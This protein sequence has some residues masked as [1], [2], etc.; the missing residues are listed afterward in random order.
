MRNYFNTTSQVRFVYPIDGDCLNIH[1]GEMKNGCL[2]IKVKVQAQAGADIYIDEKK[3]EFDGE[4]FTGQVVLRTYRTTIIAENRVDGSQ[5]TIVVY[6]WRTAP[7]NI[8]FRECRNLVSCN[9]GAY[10]GD[11]FILF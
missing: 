1:D 8:G 2:E 4:Y 7:E 5:T 6:N 10:G 3:A 9:P 11:V